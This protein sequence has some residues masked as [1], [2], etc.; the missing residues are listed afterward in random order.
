MKRAVAELTVG[1]GLTIPGNR[2]ACLITLGG[3]RYHP[4]NVRPGVGIQTNLLKRCRFRR[5]GLV[6]V[7]CVMP[8]TSST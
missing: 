3:Q 1:L 2:S 6:E 8:V 4:P 5:V 7:S